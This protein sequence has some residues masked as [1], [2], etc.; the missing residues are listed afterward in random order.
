VKQIPKNAEDWKHIYKW[1][2]GWEQRDSF[3]CGVFAFKFLVSVA[4]KEFLAKLLDAL[5]NK[6][7]C[8]AHFV[9]D[10]EIETIRKWLFIA[11]VEHEKYNIE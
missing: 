9:G 3:N 5:A 1:T 8:V 2:S 6:K 10:E 7:K 11:T 4:Q